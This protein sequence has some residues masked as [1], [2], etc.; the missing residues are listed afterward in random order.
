MVFQ[1][2]NQ[3][4]FNSKKTFEYVQGYAAIFGA[5]LD[6]ADKSVDLPALGNLRNKIGSTV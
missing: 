6:T 1:F 3:K 5:A 2:I 4:T